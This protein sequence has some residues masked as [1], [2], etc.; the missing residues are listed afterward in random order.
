MSYKLY[1]DHIG[2][3]GGWKYRVPETGVLIQG[4]SFIQLNEFVAKHYTDNAMAVPANLHDMVLEYACKNGANCDFDGVQVSK[5]SGK[6]SLNIG[7]VIR[8]SRTY[9]DALLRGDKVSQEEAN[10]RAA[11][12]AECPSNKPLEGC[13]SCNSRGLRD[14]VRFMSQHGS[15]AM[16]DRLNSCEYCGCFI[17]SMVWFPLESL[18]RFDNDNSQL[19]ANCWKK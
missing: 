13:S 1:D 14:F 4:G 11:I 19:P 8:F 18:K 12:C 5:T 3:P 17:R 16:D 9:V 6:K 15:T 10:R 7:D 2:P